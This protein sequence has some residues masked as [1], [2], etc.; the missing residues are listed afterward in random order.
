[1][2]RRDSPFLAYETIEQLC[3]KGE[4][5]ISPMQATLN[6]RKGINKG[7]YKIMSKMGIS[8]VAS[9][10][11]SKLFEAVGINNEVMKLCFKGVTS[12]I[13]GAGFDDFQQDLINLNRIAWLKRKSVDHGGLLKYVH[14]G[15]YHAYNPVSYTHLRA[16][17]TLR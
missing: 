14:G 1:M 8:T 4:L 9:Y 5:D 15:E 11:S 2:C 7:L 17:E 16:H 6:Y 13:Q 10:R 12:R 3:E